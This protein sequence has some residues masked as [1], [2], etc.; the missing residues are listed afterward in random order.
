MRSFVNCIAMSAV[1][2]A[3]LAGTTARAKDAAADDGPVLSGVLDVSVQNDYI[4]P[5]GVVVTTHGV[6]LQTLGAANL[7]LS[8]GITFTGGVWV[9]FNPGYSKTAASTRGVN[10]TDPFFGVSYKA[11]KRLTVGARYWAFVG[12]NFPRTAN[13][14]EFSAA[15]ADGDPSRPF[16]VNP[17]A[18]L[19]WEVSGSSTTGVGKNGHT[20]DVE[21][22]A[23]PTYNAGPVILSV[24]TWLTVGPKSFFGPIDDGSLG[25]ISTGLTVTKPLDLGPR[26]GKWAIYAKV[27]Y[28]H[29]ANDNLVLVKSAL[30]EGDHDSD[31][32][33]F[34]V[35]LNVGF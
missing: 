30:N 7:T 21:V 5:R 10:E 25:V 14:L 1:F 4:T 16:S 35:G 24:P 34:G 13:N 23:V 3:G 11:S 2:A 22:G 9:D 32:V 15:Y 33:Q 12:N 6:A 8:N 27:Q 19:F 26:A 28:Y 17:Y 20:F 29:L 18:K 31:Q